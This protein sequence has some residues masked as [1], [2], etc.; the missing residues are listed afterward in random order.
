MTLAQ[1]VLRYIWSS[2]SN[3]FSQRSYIFYNNSTEQTKLAPDH[4]LTA[5]LFSLRTFQLIIY[6]ERRSWGL[7]DLFKQLHLELYKQF[8]LELCHDAVNK[9]FLMKHWHTCVYQFQQQLRLAHIF[10]QPPIVSYRKEKSLK[11][12]LVRAYLPSIPLQS[13][14]VVNKEVLS[15][16][17]FSNQKEI[18]IWSSAS[19]TLSLRSRISYHNSTEQTKLAPDH[20]LAAPSF[21]LQTFQLI[22]YSERRSWGLVDFI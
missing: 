19:N 20:L 11:D 12:F 8:F 13:K 14:N 22:I 1:L 15:K 18:Y 4:L 16:G 3:T 6:S 21:S 17:L 2:A 9:K 5:P 10:N 7:V